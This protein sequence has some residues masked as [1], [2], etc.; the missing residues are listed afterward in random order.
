M[1]RTAS[2]DRALTKDQRLILD[3]IDQIIDTAGYI[4][5]DKIATRTDLSTCE[6]GANLSTVLRAS[7]EFDVTVWSDTNPKVWYVKRVS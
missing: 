2:T 4:K 3:E 6:V 5:S 1:K 7:E